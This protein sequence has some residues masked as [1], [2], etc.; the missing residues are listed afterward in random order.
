MCSRGVLVIAERAVRASDGRGSE[1]WDERALAI[2]LN[3]L[4]MQQPTLNLGQP[5]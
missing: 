5:T 1:G 3:G 2:W 4:Y